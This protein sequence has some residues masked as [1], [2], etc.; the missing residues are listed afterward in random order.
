MR[1]AIQS[2][3]RCCGVSR[4]DVN[5]DVASVTKQGHFHTEVQ[6]RPAARVHNE[7]ERD[8]DVRVSLPGWLDQAMLQE[9]DKALPRLTKIAT[10]ICRNDNLNIFTYLFI[11]DL[12]ELRKGT[13]SGSRSQTHGTAPPVKWPQNSRAPSGKAP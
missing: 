6:P 13:A 10:N 11:V 5:P 4:K 9:V 8:V 12:N 1:A 3:T 7:N 2:A